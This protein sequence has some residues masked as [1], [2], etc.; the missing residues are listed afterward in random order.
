MDTTAAYQRQ[1]TMERGTSSYFLV[2]WPLL[3]IIVQKLRVVI[4][5]QYDVAEGLWEKR[6]V[7]VDI[8][9]IVLS[10]SVKRKYLVAEDASPNQLTKYGRYLCYEVVRLNNFL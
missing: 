4:F 10:Q 6:F 2:T 7:N 8:A 9:R 3:V 5:L 1:L